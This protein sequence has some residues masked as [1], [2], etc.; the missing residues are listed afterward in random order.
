MLTGPTG[1]IGKAFTR[2]AQSRGHEIAGL[3]IPG[4]A[5]P[6]DLTAPTAETAQ[7]FQPAPRPVVWLHGT[8]EEAPWKEISAFGAEV[9]VHTAWITTPGVYLESPENERFR[10][11]SLSFLSRFRDLGANHIVGLGTCIEYHITNQPLS[12]DHTPIVPTTT[13]ARCKNQLRTALEADANVHGLV[14]C[15]GRVFY[16]YARDE[17]IILK[18]PD[19]TKDYIYISDLAEALLMVVEKK[20]RG[21]INLGTGVGITVKQIAQTIGQEMGKAHLVEEAS[22]PEPDPF[23]FVVG[24]ARKLQSLGWRQTVTMKEGL[25]RLVRARTAPARGAS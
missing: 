8:L 21:V 6:T 19:S 2:L 20:F 14:F 15:W 16:P 17:K 9:C 18:T 25:A 12:E 13:Y 7:A 23:P 24:Q 1:F 11:A 5:V 22:D 4:E 10:D 3:L